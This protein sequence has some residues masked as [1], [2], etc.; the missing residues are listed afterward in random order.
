MRTTSGC[1][2]SGMSSSIPGES[3][4]LGLEEVLAGD[5][6]GERGFTAMGRIRRFS[7]F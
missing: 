1:V 6:E 5:W 4:R 2:N 3:E 7:L